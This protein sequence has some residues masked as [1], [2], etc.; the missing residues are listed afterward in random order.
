MSNGW[1]AVTYV[2]DDGTT[3]AAMPA[4]HLEKQEAERIKKAW[5]KFLP[6]AVFR[7]R[8]SRMGGFSVEKEI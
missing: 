2:Y 5:Q 6:K 1:I 4:A 3:N 7:I 8:P